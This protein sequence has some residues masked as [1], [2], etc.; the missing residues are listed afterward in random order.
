M[1]EGQIEIG[2][3]NLPR[4]LLGTSPFIAAG[5]FGHRARLYQLDLYNQPEN[6]FK[7]IKKSY[8]LG[9]RGIQLIPYPPVLD[10][11]GLAQ[12]EGIELS[13]IGTVRPGEET[14]DIKLLSQLDAD[15]MLLHGAIADGCKWDVI[16]GHLEAIKNEGSI[17]GLATHQPF[18]T[19]AKL[20]ESPVLDSFDIYMIPVNK[21]GYLMD[22]EF[23]LEKQRNEFS[24][25]INK[26]KKKVI[27]KKTLAAGILT[28]ENAFEFL[29]TVD[30]ADMITV[31]IAYEN[32]AEETFTVLGEK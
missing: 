16:S 10:A 4:T 13:I 8:D 25:L 30:Y 24:E 28:P 32:E 3:R 23:F 17:P 27:V 2:G 14:K 15:A 26:V 9:V 1:F 5:Q 21:V 6:I 7:V 31:G 18:R 19:T 22:T 20:L 11:Y 29:K 12:D